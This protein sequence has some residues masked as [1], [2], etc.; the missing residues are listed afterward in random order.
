[1]LNPPGQ[2]PGDFA[3]LRNLTLNRGAGRV[4]LPAG[5]YGTLIANRGTRLVLG[6]AGATE[7]AVYNL[8]GLTLNARAQ[9]AVAGRW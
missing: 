9:A 7:P 1:M 2:A 5:T 6:V 3:T 4:A 8:Q